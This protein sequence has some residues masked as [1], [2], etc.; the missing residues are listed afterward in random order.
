VRNRALVSL[1][2][3]QLSGRAASRVSLEYMPT[4]YNGPKATTAGPS[5]EQWHMSRNIRV[6][7]RDGPFG[8]YPRDAEAIW[9]KRSET[10]QQ[11]LRLW[12]LQRGEQRRALMKFPLPSQFGYRPRAFLES[13]TSPCPTFIASRAWRVMLVRMYVTKAKMSADTKATSEWLPILRILHATPFSDGP[14]R[15]SFGRSVT[16]QTLVGGAVNILTCSAAARENQIIR[17]VCEGGGDWGSAAR[18]TA[19]AVPRRR[20][21]CT[22]RE[23]LGSNS[24]NLSSFCGEEAI[25]RSHNQQVKWSLERGW[26]RGGNRA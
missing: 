12:I 3:C 2:E 13:A 4:R 8:R 23:S 25:A 26:Q 19:G 5:A 1:G 11:S 16:A 9:Q 24:H 6:P 10:R 20:V 14:W 21:T 22:A 15:G 17:S 18:I 7:Q